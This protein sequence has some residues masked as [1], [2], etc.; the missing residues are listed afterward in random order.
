MNQ[1][2]KTLR[3]TFPDLNWH[4]FTEDDCWRFCESRS[5]VV[6]RASLGVDGYTGSRNV[7]GKKRTYILLDDKLSGVRLTAAFLH[8]IGHVL[9][10]EPTGSTDV[11]YLRRENALE[12]RA[13]FEADLFMLLALI[14]RPLLFEM[15][16][17]PP[18]ELHPFGG[19]LLSRRQRLYELIGE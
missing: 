8:E 10:H 11:L 12:T 19:D 5:I 17:A 18:D 13:E 14:P 1:A 7:K 6:R 2:L 4:P 15:Q 3:K 16:S 9:L